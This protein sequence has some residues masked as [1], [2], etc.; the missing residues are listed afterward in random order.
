[1]NLITAAKDAS[2]FGVSKVLVSKQTVF[3]SL[4]VTPLS[5]FRFKSNIWFNQE[6]WRLK[7]TYW[8]FTFTQAIV[9]TIFLARMSKLPQNIIEWLSSLWTVELD[10]GSSNFIPLSQIFSLLMW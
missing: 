7:H 10:T 5:P 9:I 6:A 2:A 4:G 3:N 1:M 8:K